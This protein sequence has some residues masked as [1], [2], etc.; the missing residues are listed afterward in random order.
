MH[1]FIEDGHI[2]RKLMITRTLCCKSK[3]TKA[4][5]YQKIRF[6]AQQAPRNMQYGHTVLQSPS[7]EIFLVRVYLCKS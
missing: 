7:K 3:N 5:G 4:G 2:D 6:E 1:I